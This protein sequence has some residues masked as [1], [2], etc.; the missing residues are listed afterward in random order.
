MGLGGHYQDYTTAG[1]L[2]QLG[3]EGTS[4]LGIYFMLYLPQ[5][6]YSVFAP[7]ILLTI[8]SLY[9]FMNAL[10]LFLRAPM[11]PLSIVL[12][13]KIAK[14]LLAKCRSSYTALGDSF[15]ENF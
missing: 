1:E 2:V 6:L 7:V 5:L 9:D 3:G 4:Q 13:Q 14:K 10:V 8:I 15:L 11:I 12:I